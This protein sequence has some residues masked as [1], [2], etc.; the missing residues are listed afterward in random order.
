[1]LCCVEKNKKEGSQLKQKE[2]AGNALEDLVKESIPNYKKK[3]R[4]DQSSM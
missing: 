3:G 1:M 2:E 4:R